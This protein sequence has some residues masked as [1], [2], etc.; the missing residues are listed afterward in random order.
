MFVGGVGCPI[1]WVLVEHGS[2]INVGQGNLITR[3]VV[4]K[5]SKVGWGRLGG[6]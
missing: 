4:S 5:D 3:I 1:R 6:L 2:G